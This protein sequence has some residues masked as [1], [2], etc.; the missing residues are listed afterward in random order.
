MQAPRDVVQAMFERWEADPVSAM[1]M[2]APDV[3]YSLNVSPEVLLLGGETV[4]W[5]AVN[6]L[7]LDIR[8]VFDYLVF[9]PRILTV[10]G[11]TVRSRIELLLRHKASG[12]L[13]S[14]QMRSV[15]VVRD[16]YIARV[17][18]YVDAPMIEAFMRLFAAGNGK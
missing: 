14:G 17:D 1:R 15:I 5:H 11:N 18:E 8:E 12:E 2:V 16:G 9:R 7:M 10:E 3:V 4:G 6:K 13:L